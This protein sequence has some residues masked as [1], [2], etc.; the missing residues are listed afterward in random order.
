MVSM[1]IGGSFAAVICDTPGC[2]SIMRVPPAEK[3]EQSFALRAK[4][5]LIAQG[6]T[7]DG[8]GQDRCPACALRPAS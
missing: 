1:A 6:W 5:M 8:R 3:T 4:G 2:L 7:K